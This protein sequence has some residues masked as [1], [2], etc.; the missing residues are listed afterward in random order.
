MQP[1]QDRGGND[2]VAIR[3]SVPIW[4]RELAEWHV[5]NSRTQAGVWSTLVVVSDPLLQDGP[6]VPFIQHNQGPIAER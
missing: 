4:S 1:R 6:K 2:S 3:D 5:G